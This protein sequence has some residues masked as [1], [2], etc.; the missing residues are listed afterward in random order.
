M[1]FKVQSHKKQLL[2]LY[3]FIIDM[4]QDQL[5]I[6]FLTISDYMRYYETIELESDEPQLYQQIC[7]KLNGSQLLFEAK[8]N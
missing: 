4:Y 5:Y 7:S 6:T 2:I 8:N 1:Y 3:N